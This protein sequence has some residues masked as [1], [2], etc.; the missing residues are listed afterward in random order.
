MS[1]KSRWAMLPFSRQ[2]FWATLALLIGIVFFVEVL[3]ETILEPLFTA[4]FGE[5]SNLHEGILWCI[6]IVV[7]SVGSSWF[8]SRFVEKKLRGPAEASRRLAEGDLSAR[9]DLKENREDAFGRVAVAFNS[10]AQKLEDLFTMERRLLADISH[11]LRSPLTRMGMALALAEHIADTPVQRHLETMEKELERMSELVALLLQ[12]GRQ[13]LLSAEQGLIDVGAVLRAVAADAAFEG[14][15]SGKTLDCVL[16]EGLLV[17]GGSM[18]LRTMF[19]NVVNNA[20]R[21]TPNGASVVVRA[22]KEGEVILVEVRD[23]GPGVPDSM[24]EDIFHPFFRVDD[25]R[26]RET[27]G[28]G[29]GLALAKQAAHAHGGAITASVAT[30]GL[31]MLVTLPAAKE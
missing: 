23:Y 27:G 3:G 2:V 29:L 9:I 18:S 26:N 31:R 10:M 7:P 19:A 12:Q 28:V 20:L 4:W 15:D 13:S 5:F 11:E 14:Q 17:H 30:P 21:Y 16:E 24:L 1:L 8:L 25:S 6:G 22:R